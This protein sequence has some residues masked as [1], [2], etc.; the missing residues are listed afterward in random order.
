MLM[1]L[2]FYASAI[3]QL[4]WITACI[5]EPPIKR[6]VGFAFINSLCNTPNIWASYLYTGAPRYLPAFAVNLGAGVG[7]CGFAVAIY[8]YLR[9]QNSRLAQG[10]SMPKSGPTQ[11]QIASG[12]KY[13]L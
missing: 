6:A 7:A 4:S 3:I 13:M 8:F 12:Y 5:N 2:S 1:P 9:R 11:E 10:L